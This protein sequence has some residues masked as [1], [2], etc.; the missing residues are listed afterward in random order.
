MNYDP[1]NH[2]FSE[3]VSVWKPSVCI[4]YNGANPA[5]L[6]GSF[7]WTDIILWSFHFNCS[8]PWNV[9][10]AWSFSLIEIFLLSTFTSKFSVGQSDLFISLNSSLL[11]QKRYRMDRST[12]FP[13]A[14][15][16]YASTPTASGLKSNSVTMPSQC[17]AF[18]RDWKQG[19]QLVMLVVC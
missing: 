11:Q 5:A 15:Q 17:L 3:Q 8:H 16:Q 7:L 10:S 13:T 4:T 12:S 19:Y 1:L 2:G 14:S 18:L 6:S 9:Y